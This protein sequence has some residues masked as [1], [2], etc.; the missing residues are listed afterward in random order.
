MALLTP[1][2]FRRAHCLFLLPGR[3]FLRL[4]IPAGTKLVLLVFAGAVRMLLFLL[5]LVFVLPFLLMGWL[6]I[7]RRMS[8]RLLWSRRFFLA[9][10]GGLSRSQRWR[11]RRS[12]LILSLLLSLRSR[13]KLRRDEPRRRWWT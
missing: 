4:L 6:G 8:L 5:V 10:R 13:P 1:R 11:R 7:G 3:V 12:G 9:A 2:S